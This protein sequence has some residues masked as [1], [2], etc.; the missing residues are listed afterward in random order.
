MSTNVHEFAPVDFLLEL[1]ARF[2]DFYSS[3]MS[4]FPTDVLVNKVP[5]SEGSLISRFED[6]TR[7]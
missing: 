4:S 3:L 6:N 7:P 1:G 5:G 2:G